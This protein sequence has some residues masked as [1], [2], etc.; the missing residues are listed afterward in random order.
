M[1]NPPTTIS[2]YIYGAKDVGKSPVSLE[3]LQ[4][5][6][7]TVTMTEE[8]FRY[9]RLAGD[10]L[11]DQIEEVINT[12]RGVIG[13]T[14]HLA[15]YF[16]TP[17]GGAD[18]NYKA[19]AKERFKQWILD[20]CRRPYDQDWLNYQH[21]IGQRHTHLKKNK[22]DEASAPPHIPLRYVIA[23]TAV[24]NDTIRPFLAKKGNPLEEIEAMH[25]AWCKAVILHVTLWSR[26]YVA[27]SDW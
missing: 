5:L 17:N 27:E 23:F 1:S 19:R 11:E 7:Q 6:E 20:V 24:I 9:L 18:E 22:T 12:W 13:K 14:P 2:G 15:Y 8:D 21:E 4:R 25:R 3:D 16:M 26:T 10:V